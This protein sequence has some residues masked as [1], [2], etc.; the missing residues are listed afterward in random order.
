METKLNIR[1]LHGGGGME[2]KKQDIAMHCTEMNR[3]RSACGMM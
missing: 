1:Q 3:V 2:E